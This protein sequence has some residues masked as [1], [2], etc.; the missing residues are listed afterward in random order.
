[1]YE[2]IYLHLVDFYG[3]HVGIYIYHLTQWI[4]W[5]SFLDGKKSWSLQTQCPQK[6]H[7]NELQVLVTFF[8][9][10]WWVDVLRDPRAALGDLQRKGWG[11]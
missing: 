3:F 4:L 11:G 8:G 1:M 10:G 7:G 2:T 5:N 9:G 6:N